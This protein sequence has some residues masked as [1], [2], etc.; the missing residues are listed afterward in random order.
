MLVSS[1]IF[2]FSAGCLAAII[3]SRVTAIR[4]GKISVSHGNPP[5]M[6]LDKL[7]EK[8]DE[9]LILAQTRSIEAIL[10]AIAKAIVLVSKL[11]T[12]IK[13]AV[14]NLLDKIPSES[15]H[16]HKKGSASFFLKD[17]SAYKARIQE[18]VKKE[19]LG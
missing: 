12:S 13:S 7:D 18:K 17:I 19:M 10:S 9:F 4:R 6:S 11:N 5:F 3:F 15:H 14:R 8:V 2:A 16:H 1:V